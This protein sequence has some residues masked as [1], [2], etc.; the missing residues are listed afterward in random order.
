M[1]KRDIYECVTKEISKVKDSLIIVEG[2]K[3][4]NALISLNIPSKNIFPINEDGRSLYEKIEEIENIA[5]KTKK[6]CVILTDFD[7]KGKQLYLIIKKELSNCGVKINNNLRNLLIKLNISH[8][9]GLDTF[10]N[11]FMK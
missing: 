7:K 4:K 1:N 8:I 6:S 5:K 10:F 11:K 2:K 9:E 3:D